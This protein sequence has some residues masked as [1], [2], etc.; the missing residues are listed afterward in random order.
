MCALVYR[1]QATFYT[2]TKA[3]TVPGISVVCL[4]IK[5]IKNRYS[6][7]D[8]KHTFYDINLSMVRNLESVKIGQVLQMF[9]VGQFYGIY[10]G[11][12]I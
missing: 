4:I 9:K 3:Q 11:I 7:N 12:I 5:N 10:D 1:V 8:T 2:L 6:K